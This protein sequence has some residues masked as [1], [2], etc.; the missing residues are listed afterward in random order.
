M[1]KKNLLSLIYQMIK[2]NQYLNKLKYPNQLA[3]MNL[4]NS[5]E[6]NIDC[7]GKKYIWNSEWFNINQKYV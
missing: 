5:L 4:L 2:C 1:S 3:V 7:A 6:K